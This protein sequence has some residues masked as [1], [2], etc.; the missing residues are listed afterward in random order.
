MIS[1]NYLAFNFHSF[2]NIDVMKIIDKEKNTNLHLICSQGDDGALSR[3]LSSAVEVDLEVKNGAANTPL[4]EAINEGRQVTVE[5]LLKLGSKRTDNCTN[6]GNALHAAVKTG[7]PQLVS[8]VLQSGAVDLETKNLAGE[9][10]LIEAITLC[11]QQ[12]VELLFEAG[13]NTDSC[14][15]KG[16][17]VLHVAIKTGKLEL[18]RTV[19]K[20]VKPMM[21][22]NII[23]SKEGGIDSKEGGPPLH[24]AIN[25]CNE[26]IILELINYAV[27][28]QKD[29]LELKDQKLLTPFVA[30]IRK[31]SSAAIA[32]A[33]IDAGFD[34]NTRIMN[35]DGKE[36]WSVLH[37]ACANNEAF[38][39]VLLARGAL[40]S[41]GGPMFRFEN[42]KIECVSKVPPIIPAASK[43]SKELVQALINAGDDPHFV[44]E[45]GTNPLYF[46]IENRNIDVLE[47][48]LKLGV[49]LNPKIPVDRAPLFRAKGNVKQVQLLLEHGANMN[50]KNS[51]KET[52]FE[53]ICK[54]SS[55]D[56][57]LVSLFLTHGANPNILVSNGRHGVTKLLH[58]VV[59]EEGK[60]ELF[61]AR[62]KLIIQLLN[63]GANAN[64]KDANGH[65]SLHKFIY[66]VTYPSKYNY[67]YK[68]ETVLQITQ[69]FIDKGASISSET[70]KLFDEYLGKHPNETLR[71]IVD[72]KHAAECIIM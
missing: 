64:F 11:N 51:N 40:I 60:K 32:N 71:A 10:P 7:I 66:W 38:A 50:I 6:D 35:S 36:A 31:K 25:M 43:G 26:P 59:L 49:N 67:L 72:K 28:N 15:D 37:E 56:Y 52:P 24:Y 33:F 41:T 46:A 1:S 63:A 30:A 3:V 62:A 39:M 45:D 58:K 53:V 21:M 23:D 57:E 34:V 48:F 47:L 44:C 20:Y 54:A 9:T 18:V 14:T 5:L 2:S 29:A 8:I 12:I 17:T 4:I 13:A 61:D 70:K 55:L 69:L 27:E 68:S 19:L 42:D 65:N 16:W 22:T